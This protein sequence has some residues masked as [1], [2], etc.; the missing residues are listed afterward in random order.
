[1]KRFFLILV[2]L[3]CTCIVNGQHQ[4]TTGSRTITRWKLSS[5]FTEEIA[6]PFDTVF[7]LFNRFR[8][9]DQYS[10]INVTLGSYGLPFYQVNF[11][12]RVNDPDSYLYIYYYPLMYQP[13]NYVFMNTQVPFTEAVWTYGGARETAEQTFRVRHS[14]NVNR[15]LNFGLEYDIVYNLGQYS[16]Q[17]AVDKDFTLYG[18]Y[19]GPRYNVYLGTGLNNISSLENGGISDQSQLTTLETRNVAVNLGGL[20]KARN[21]LKNRNLMLVQRY[22]VGARPAVTKD[23]ANSADNTPFRLSGTFTH[24]LVLDGNK[25]T[26]SDD[27]PLSGFYDT[28]YINDKVTLDSLTARAVK[29]TIRFDFSTDESRLFRLGGGVGF[30]NELFRYSQIIPLPDTLLADTALW[31]RHNNVLTGKLYNDI[32]N[33]FRWT[34]AGELYLTGY[35]AGDFNLTGI[36]SKSFNWKK[37]PAAWNITGGLTNRQPSFWMTKWGSNHFT[38]NMNQ[39]KEFRVDLGTSFI[40]PGRNTEIKLNYAIIDNY[41][42]FDTLALPAQYHGGLSAASLHVKKELSAWKFHLLT[43]LLVQKSSNSSILDLPLVATRTSVFFEHLFNFVR[44]NGQLNTQLGADLTW[45]SSYYPYSYMPSTGRFYRQEKKL[46]GNY[47][48]LNIF[49]NLKIRRTRIFLMLDHVNSG[50]TGYDY[51]MVPLYPMNVRM[52]RYGIAWTFYD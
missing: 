45:H 37:G 17:R 50:F 19:R 18:S 14:R 29:N 3:S 52:F 9:A 2:W 7:S 23:T 4:D 33:K 40:Y 38:W 30:R 24:I 39:E 28:V 8:L 20:N 51:Y 11:F 6:L 5:D 25:R 42:D 26:Y 48:F 1:M 35:R 21:D 32:G 49:L 44:S 36:I 47:P 13:G 43:D 31:H 27:F 12:D 22:T 15:Y 10:P 34:A 41:T 16:Y 46:T